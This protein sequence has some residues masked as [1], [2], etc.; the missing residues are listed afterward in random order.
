MTGQFGAG[1]E[2]LSEEQE[3][4]ERMR[5]HLPSRPAGWFSWLFPRGWRPD[6]HTCERIKVNDL[7]I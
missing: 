5:E 6:T 3:V 1:W 2:G 4:G 7:T